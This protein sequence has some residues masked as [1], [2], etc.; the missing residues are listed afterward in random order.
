MRFKL[1]GIV[2]A[3]VTPFTKNGDYVDF[4]KI[5][6]VAEG[7][8]RMGAHGLF[9]CG[10]TGEG[11][12]MTAEERKT[13][14]EEVVASVGSSKAKIIAHSGAMDTATTIELT[15]HAAE[16]GADASA[17]VTPPF[18]PFDDKAIEQHFSAV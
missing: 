7:V 6:G 2:A 1:E 12:L 18:Y 15:V 14:L 17:V 4:D 11:M 10:T 16:C 13:V 9:V 8:L 5:G 3:M